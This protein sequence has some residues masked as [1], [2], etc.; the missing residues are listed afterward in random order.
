M[1]RHALIVILSLLIIAA[2]L[3]AACSTG[4]A[5]TAPPTDSSAPPSSTDY[6]AQIRA[7]ENKILELQQNQ[8]LSD[9][10]YQK[11][12]AELTAQ[13][14]A[15]KAETTPPSTTPPSEEPST[16]KPSDSPRFL[17]TVSNNK[18][19]ITGYTGN[20]T[21]LV[22]PAAIDGYAG[23]SKVSPFLPV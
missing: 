18:A 6:T 15:L 19:T 16:T 20:A 1:K 13:L 2:C 10:E 7:L 21:N 14:E 9:A 3:F 11:E 8:S 22:I 5:S 23:M 12:L 4:S 17:Y